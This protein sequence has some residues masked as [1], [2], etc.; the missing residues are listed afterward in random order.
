MVVDSP[1]ISRFMTV[2]FVAVGPWWPATSTLR[3]MPGRLLGSPIPGRCR[4]SEPLPSKSAVTCGSFRDMRLAGAVFANRA[5]VVDDML[6]VEGGFWATTSVA[7]H[8]ELFQCCLS[9]YAIPGDAT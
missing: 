2:P 7:A 9:C 4:T 6:N 8:S 1:T 3:R 5:D